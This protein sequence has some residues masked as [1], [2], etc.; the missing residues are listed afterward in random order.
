MHL[1][2]LFHVRVKG[3]LNYFNIAVKSKIAAID[4][5]EGLYALVMPACINHWSLNDAY[6]ATEVKI[7]G[8]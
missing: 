6:Y 4:P 5:F 3:N 1:D 7:K 8:D 2:V